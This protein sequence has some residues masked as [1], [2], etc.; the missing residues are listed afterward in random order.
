VAKTG[1]FGSDG[2][3]G[4]NFEDRSNCGLSMW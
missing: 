1:K 2:S 4:E 3:D